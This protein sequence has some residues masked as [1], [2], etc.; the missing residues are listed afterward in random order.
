M[1]EYERQSGEATDISLTGTQ[2]D[3]LENLAYHDEDVPQKKK[4]PA[5]SAE[6]PEEKAGI[7]V[8]GAKS[9]EDVKKHSN[10]EAA[11]HRVRI[12]KAPIPL[13]LTDRHRISPRLY[14]QERQEVRRDPHP[15]ADI[16]E[17]KRNV[18]SR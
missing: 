3:L 14:M 1:E 2:A 10:A 9:R 7:K 13:I 6:E 15:R 12:R 8:N 5:I 11:K 18:N 17:E 16:P 4:R